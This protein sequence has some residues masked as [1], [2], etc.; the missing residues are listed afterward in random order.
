VVIRLQNKQIKSLKIYRSLKVISPIK[1]FSREAVTLVKKSLRKI[2]RNARAI[3]SLFDN[4]E[5]S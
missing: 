5:N 1:I 4:Y 3:K 2:I